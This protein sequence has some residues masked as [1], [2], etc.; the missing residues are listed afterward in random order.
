MFSLC[1]IQFLVLLARV[2]SSLLT[3]Y[4]SGVYFL[5]FLL[6]GRGSLSVYVQSNA[7]FRSY[8]GTCQFWKFSHGSIGKIE[9]WFT[10]WY[11]SRFVN[12]TN[13]IPL[14]LRTWRR[15]GLVVS[16]VRSPSDHA[17]RVRALETL[18]C[19]AG[20]NAQCL[21]PPMCINWYQQI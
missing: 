9:E 2:L 11:Y 10:T 16:T 12:V 17:I 4:I 13:Y 8:L 7:S 6:L 18:C 5:L 21:S 15:S 19:V 1:C 3:S 14:G 20:L